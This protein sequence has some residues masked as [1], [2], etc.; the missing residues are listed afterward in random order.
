MGHQYRLFAGVDWGTEAHQ[1]WAGDREGRRIGERTVEH[2]GAALIALAEWLVT[3]ADGEASAVAV[4]LEVPRGPIVDTLLERGCHVFAINPKQLDRFRDRYSAAG[5]KDDRRDA[6]ALSSA[7]RTDQPAFRRLEVDDPQTVQLR[8]YAR[9]DTE[10]AEDLGR[11]ANRLRDHLVRVWPELLRFAPAADEAWLWTL[12]ARM[13]VPREPARIRPTWIRHLL[14]THR[15]RRFAADDL[16]TVLRTPS[17]RLAPGVRE[18]VAPRIVN[19]VEQL[20]VLHAQRRHTE[21]RLAELLAAMTGEDRPEETREHHDIVIL[22]SLPGIGIRITATM[23]AEAAAA[24]RARDY[25]AL[26]ILAGSAPVTK[27]SGKSRVVR[28]RYACN[29]RLQTALYYWGQNSLRTDSRSRAHYAR[30]R[31]A[32]HPHARALRGVTD[33]LLAVLVAA[34]KTRTLY[35]PN[36]R[37]PIDQ[38]A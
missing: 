11:V 15:I 31:A 35:D 6:E 18:G 37:A 27:Q 26:R 33:R 32:G 28:M 1:V 25:H 4:A 24:L 3:L 17:V 36:R 2:T 38:S 23:L 21:R 29:H 30:L 12:L 14:R 9:H 8:E 5:A 34:L 19:L 13:P 22:Q 16:V 10:L 20:R 7:L